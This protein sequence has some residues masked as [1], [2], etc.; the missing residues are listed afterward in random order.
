MIQVGDIVIIEYC[1]RD[2][3]GKTALVV[4]ECASDSHVMVMVL[5][6]LT[7]HPYSIR[8]LT[9]LGEQQ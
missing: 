3:K 7:R 8:R 1:T 4:E 5:D 6:T 2:R 9:K